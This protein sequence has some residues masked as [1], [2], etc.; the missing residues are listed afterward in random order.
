MSRNTILLADDDAAIRS[1]QKRILN[2]EFKEMIVD[3]FSNGTSLDE[4][5]RGK[6]DNVTLIITDNEMPGISGS[7]IIRRYAQKFNI[8]FILHYGGEER[9]G[10]QAVTDGAFGFL[11]KPTDLPSYIDLVGRALAKSRS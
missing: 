2:G 6:I 1:I 7:E 11:T 10:E 9:K 8:P 3:E 4:R 5:I